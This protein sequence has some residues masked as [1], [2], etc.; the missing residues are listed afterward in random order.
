MADDLATAAIA[1][2]SLPP[3]MEDSRVVARTAP[4]QSPDDAIERGIQLF[5][6]WVG[7][8][9]FIGTVAGIIY[10]VA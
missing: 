2:H 9:A 1:Q 6:R 10:L 4:L 7:I 8:L 5:S 3:V